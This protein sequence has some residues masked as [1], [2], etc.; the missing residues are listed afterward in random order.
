MFTRMF[1][2]SLAALTLA[3]L[4]A[5]CVIAAQSYDG[6]VESAGAGKIGI[7][8]SNGTIH[9]F[10]VDAGAKITLDGKDAKLDAIQAGASATV[11]TEVKDNQTVAVTIMARSKLSND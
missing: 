9:E 4:V 10:A 3:W 2:M 1:A 5:T 11:V 7:K 6:T 8:D